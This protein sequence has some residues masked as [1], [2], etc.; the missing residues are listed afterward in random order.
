[1]QSD[2]TNSAV[3]DVSFPEIRAVIFDMDGL[4]LDTE[5]LAQ[6]AWQQAGADLGYD[7][8]DAIYRQAIG[9]TAPA[10]EVIFRGHFGAESPFEAIYERKQQ[11]YHAAIEEGRVALKAGLLPLLDCIDRL[12]L[13]KAV[14]TSTARPL[15]L[16]KLRATNLLDRFPHIVCGNEVANGKP[17]PDI[18]LA[19]AAKLNVPPPVCLVLEDSPAGIRAAHAAGMIPIHV[20]DLVPTTDDIRALAH[21]VVADLHAVCVLLESLY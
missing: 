13:P 15:A 20:P 21:R 6:E 1:M 14:A 5:R 17:A 11:Y 8:P 7:L 4:M 19:A 16:Q 9:R 10:T 2:Q 3:A 18:F 12:G